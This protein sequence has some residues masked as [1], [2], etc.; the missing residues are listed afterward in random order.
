M[1]KALPNE[2]IQEVDLSGIKGG[3]IKLVGERKLI[4]ARDKLDVGKK[5]IPITW[6]GRG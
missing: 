1:M 6:K 3:D 5:T 4:V 2:Y